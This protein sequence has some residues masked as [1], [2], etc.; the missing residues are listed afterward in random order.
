MDAGTSDVGAN[1]T[2]TTAVDGILGGDSQDDHQWRQHP[3]DAESVLRSVGGSDA[4]FGGSSASTTSGG[5]SRATGIAGG[6]DDDI[7]VN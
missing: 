5:V 7:L 6:A 2:A 1:L 3:D 4:T